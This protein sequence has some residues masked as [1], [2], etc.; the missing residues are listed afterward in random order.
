MKARHRQSK[1]CQKRMRRNPTSTCILLSDLKPWCMMTLLS[2]VGGLLYNFL[3]ISYV[4]IMSGSWV[5]E[6]NPSICKCISW[7][8]GC[9]SFVTDMVKYV[10]MIVG[11]YYCIKFYCPEDWKHLLVSCFCYRY[12]WGYACNYYSFFFHYLMYNTRDMRFLLLAYK[13]TLCARARV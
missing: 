3:L 6:V 5:T 13:I 10:E 9:G 1:K 7:V 4:S 2:P 12:W 8:L 11:C